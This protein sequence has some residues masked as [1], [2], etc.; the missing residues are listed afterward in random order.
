MT[1]CTVK[2]SSV[3]ARNDQTMGKADL[4]AGVMAALAGVAILVG[5]TSIPQGSL[6]NLGPSLFPRLIGVGLAI[7]G[8]ILAIGGLRSATAQNPFQLSRAD[9][10]R[11]AAVPAAILAY[12]A[13]YHMAGFPLA[14]FVVVSG[15]SLL[16]TR[17]LR[18]SILLG[19]F[20]VAAIQII[21]VMGLGV[22]L[23]AGL[24]QG[25]LGS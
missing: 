12:L 25:V 9:V 1:N 21:F 16:L 23:D 19:V 8:G 5:S 2:P 15:L 7:A 20:S 24:L 11:G 13:I 4:I 14:G 6:G 18:A 22:P 10:A 3:S 17:R